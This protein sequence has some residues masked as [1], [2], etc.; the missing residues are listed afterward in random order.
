MDRYVWICFSEVD[1]DVRA[2]L[3]GVADRAV[4]QTHTHTHTHTH[5][6]TR[7]GETKTVWL[8]ANVC[9]QARTLCRHALLFG[10]ETFKVC[11]G[12]LGQ[13]LEV[14]LVHGCECVDSV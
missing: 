9:E 10:G 2:P 13:N 5:T 3:L 8:N 1:Q 11:L 12:C 14:F 4:G 7:V 6:K